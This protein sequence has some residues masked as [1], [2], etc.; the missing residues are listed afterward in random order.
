M[1]VAGMA[2]VVSQ[3]FAPDRLTAGA[4]LRAY[5]EGFFPMACGDGV[6]R[7]FSPDP[8]GIMPLE[9]FHVPHGLRRVLRRTDFRATVDMAFGEVV[10]G[11]ADRAE[12]WIDPAIARVYGVLHERGAAHSVEI[13]SGGILAGGLYGVRIGGAFFGESMFSRVS[14]ASKTALVVLADI[15]RAGGFRLLDIQWMTGHLRGFGA[16][17]VERA[18][19]LALLR[20]AVAHACLFPAP[21]PVAVPR[22]AR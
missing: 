9:D 6:M 2:D 16:V 18:V 3:S 14:Q 4:V 22:M 19:Y 21:G 10:A 12:T 11:C 17:E 20:N 7:W 13:W 1:V 8:R 15:L 5:R